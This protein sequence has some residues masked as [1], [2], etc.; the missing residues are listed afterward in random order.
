MIVVFVIGYACIALE[1]PLGINK[2]ATA[3]LLGSLMWV[4]LTCM[5]PAIA[6]IDIHL[7]EHLGETAE[8]LF[9]LLGAMTIV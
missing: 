5:E 9:F 1:H 6:S 2:T 8:I 4:F 7:I 3:L